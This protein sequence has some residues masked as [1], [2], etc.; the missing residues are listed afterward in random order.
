MRTVQS[1]VLPRTYSEESTTNSVKADKIVIGKS[2]E[3]DDSNS[4]NHGSDPTARWQG[5]RLIES[6]EYIAASTKQPPILHIDTRQVSASSSVRERSKSFLSRPMMTGKSGFK[7]ANVLKQQDVYNVEEQ[8]LLLSEQLNKPTAH[9]REKSFLRRALSCTC[10]TSPRSLSAE[11]LYSAAKTGDLFFDRKGVVLEGQRLAHDIIRCPA[12]PRPV[13]RN[14]VSVCL[15]LCVCLCVCLSDVPCGGRG[16]RSTVDGKYIPK[17]RHLQLWTRVGFL[18]SLSDTSAPPPAK[19]RRLSWAGRPA[20]SQEATKYVLFADN[21]GLRLTALRDLLSI[22]ELTASLT[23]LDDNRYVASLRPVLVTGQG[24]AAYCTYADGLEEIASACRLSGGCLP[25]EALVSPVEASTNPPPS[26]SV[27]LTS[28]GPSRQPFFQGGS[29]VSSLSYPEESSSVRLQASAWVREFADQYFSRLRGVLFMPSAENIAEAT[30]CFH[31]IAASYPKQQR[32]E[33]DSD[34]LDMSGRAKRGV[35]VPL[36]FLK[37]HLA[38]LL[39][40]GQQSGG[41]VGDQQFDE[42]LGAMLR[43]MDGDGDGSIS[44][45]GVCVDITGSVMIMAVVVAQAEFLDAFLLLP[46]HQVPL[47]LDCAAVAT[48]EMVAC[49]MSAL[50]VLKE[51]EMQEGTYFLPQSFSSAAPRQRVV[52]G[53]PERRLHLKNLKDCAEVTPK[54]IACAGVRLGRDVLL[55]IQT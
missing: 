17:R 43:H 48:A 6:G 33:E 51:S 22:V 4:H 7:V 45:V 35:Q 39:Q 40:R 37:K 14:D 47:E 27:S 20:E 53:G 8:T 42:R 34:W 1:K 9:R 54:S 23:F 24:V 29:H 28:S 12:P 26:P 31:L 15:C 3:I 18:V 38:G 49:M 44:L 50:G 36:A 21:R 2:D 55:R 10:F 41:H 5:H 46:C 19:T 11:E 32:G 16:I 30:R 13:R 52:P 25:W